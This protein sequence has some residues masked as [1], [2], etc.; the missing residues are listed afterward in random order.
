MVRTVIDRVE[1]FAGRRVTRGLARYTTLPPP[2]TRNVP[3]K[4]QG[5]TRGQKL[6]PEIR[7][8]TVVVVF[9]D[10]TP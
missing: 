2:L 3:P 5:K 6:F 7:P 10:E 9:Y 8:G 1:P 4:H